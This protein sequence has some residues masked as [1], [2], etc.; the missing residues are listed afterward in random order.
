MQNLDT[1][2]SNETTHLDLNTFAQKPYLNLQMN[3]EKAADVKENT[4]T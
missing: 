3:N 4:K 1:T 2:L